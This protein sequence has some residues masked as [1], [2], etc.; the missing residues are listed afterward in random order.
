MNP[1]PSWPTPVLSPLDAED[2]IQ[3]LR[4]TLALFSEV[5]DDRMALQATGNVYGP[6]IKTGL[7]FRDLRL[8]L[9]VVDR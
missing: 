4:H 6:G 7:T 9:A 5:E 1:D 3:N 8:I 2:A